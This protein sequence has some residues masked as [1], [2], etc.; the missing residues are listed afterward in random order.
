MVRSDVAA[1]RV[2]AMWACAYE[3]GPNEYPTHKHARKTHMIYPFSP[4][5]P[6]AMDLQ[7]R[8]RGERVADIYEQVVIRL[9]SCHHVDQFKATQFGQRHSLQDG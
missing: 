4:V 6:V 1:A 9:R 3:N 7:M 8:E 5:E 2:Q